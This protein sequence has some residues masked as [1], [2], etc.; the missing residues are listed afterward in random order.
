MRW[1]GL[2]RDLF[3]SFVL[4]FGREGGGE[5]GVLVLRVLVQGSQSSEFREHSCTGNP[6]SVN[7]VVGT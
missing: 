5:E 2:G 1:V 7:C 3:G 6:T 4:F